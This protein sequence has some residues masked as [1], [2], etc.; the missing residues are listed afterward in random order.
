MWNG[1]GT[2]PGP[3]MGPAGSGVRSTPEAASAFVSPA[4]T[5]PALRFTASNPEPLFDIEV[6]ALG[7]KVSIGVAGPAVVPIRPS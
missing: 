3:S 6:L 4:W 5:N 7:A 1:R 2:F